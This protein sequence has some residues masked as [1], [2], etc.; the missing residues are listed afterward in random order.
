MRGTE[1]V[2]DAK[3]LDLLDASEPRVD[4]FDLTRFR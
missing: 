4:A 1:T 3:R 2:D